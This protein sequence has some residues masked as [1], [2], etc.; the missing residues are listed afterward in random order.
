MSDDRKKIGEVARLVSL[1]EEE[2]ITYEE[3]ADMSDASVRT[4]KNTI[5]DNKPIGSKLLR[6]LQKKK[7]VSI[8]WLLEGVGTRYLERA[9]QVK[10][11]AATPYAAAPNGSKKAA[12]LCAW[13]QDYAST[14]TKEEF[15]W[16]EVEIARRFPEFNQWLENQGQ[17][18]VSASFV[19]TMINSIYRR[20]SPESQDKLEAYAEMLRDEQT[21]GKK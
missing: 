7:G 16:L 14:H 17:T 9:G 2:G 11:P 19:E 21:Q 3:L 12:R 5:Y 8:D 4:V 18:L 13:L 6:G 15:H 10:E 20:L 1:I